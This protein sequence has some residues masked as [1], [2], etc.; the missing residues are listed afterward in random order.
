MQLSFK[1][2][3]A[4]RDF[5]A[6]RHAKGLPGKVVDHSKEHPKNLSPYSVTLR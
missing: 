3:Q 6:K 5:N 1:T 4:A 2:R